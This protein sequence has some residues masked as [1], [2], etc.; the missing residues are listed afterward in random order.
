[1]ALVKYNNNSISGITS[2]PNVG[3]TSITLI[4]TLD[5]S[6]DAN[7]S[8]VHGSSDVVLNDTY[9]IYIF[10]LINI[11]PATNQA[12]FTVNFRDG[13]SSY[14]ATKTTTCFAAYHQE[15][16]GDTDLL[17]ASGRDLAQS[18]GVQN[19]AGSVGN[20]NDQSISGELF[21][22]NPY[23][24]E[25]VKN[26][27]CRTSYAEASDQAWTQNVSGYCNTTTAIDGVQFSFDSG[28]IDSG[29]I[30]LYGIK[31]S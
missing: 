23:S 22:F 28:N 25:F 21:L 24:N 10:K 17:Y 29:T 9:P 15:D 3:S 19:I 26:F 31:D 2:A 6:S 27:I 4:K 20:D 7:L 8:F 14:D 12:N 16:A 30:K 18:S 13:G 5:A 1:M 11:H